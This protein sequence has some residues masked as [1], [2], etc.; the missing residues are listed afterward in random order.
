VV[1]GGLVWGR[2]RRVEAA[3]RASRTSV[4]QASSTATS[5]TKPPTGNPKPNPTGRDD[6]PAT[7]SS[8]SR[9]TAYADSG[10]L[11][12]MGALGMTKAPRA[13]AWAPCAPVGF[14]ARITL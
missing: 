10:V 7:L 14:S 4:Q 8:A 11:G 9:G 3:K 5:T 12:S 1:V 6:A 13:A 2:S